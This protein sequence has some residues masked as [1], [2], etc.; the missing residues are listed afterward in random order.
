M[1]ESQVTQDLDERGLL[2]AARGPGCYALKLRVPE[3]LRRRWRRH[4]DAEPDNLDRLAAAPRAL[5][6]G[7]ASDVYGRLCEHVAADVR[8]ASVLRVCPPQRVVAVEPTSDP[9]EAEYSFARG[10]ADATTTV[11]YDGE[12]L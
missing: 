6:V 3:D 7:A 1:R 4:F 10:F 12:I 9:F 5:Y 8:R 2:D 11:W